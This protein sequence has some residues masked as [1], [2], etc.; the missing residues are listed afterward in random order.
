M[1]LIYPPAFY[2][3]Y[4][5]DSIH[6]IDINKWLIIN[7]FTPSYVIVNSILKNVITSCKGI[8]LC[9]IVKRY[10]HVVQPNELIK[11]VKNLINIGIIYTSLEDINFRKGPPDPYIT[12]TYFHITYRC[13]YRCLYCYAPPL[14]THHETEAEYWIEAA[15]NIISYN[16]SR[17][18]NIKPLIVISGGEPFIRSDIFHIISELLNIGC[19]VG[20][21]TNA[22]LIDYDKADMLKK[23]IKSNKN[24][25]LLPLCVS[26]D[27]YIQKINDQQRILPGG[28]AYS[29][30]MRGIKILK[31]K[32]IPFYTESTLT[33]L[34]SKTAIG[35]LKYFFSIST[36]P[37][38]HTFSLFT[39]TGKGA[40]H[41][42]LDLLQNE[43]KLFRI[44][45]EIK[46]LYNVLVKRKTKNIKRGI[47]LR[48]NI[49]RTLIIEP[50]RFK[51]V[52]INS[53]PAATRTLSLDPHLNVFPCHM[54]MIKELYGGTFF[55]DRIYDI[56]ESK[57]FR[58]I[59]NIVV[60]DNIY[61]RYCSIKYWCGGRCKAYTYFHYNNDI[62]A[63]YNKRRPFCSHIRRTVFKWFKS[64]ALNISREEYN[65]GIKYEGKCKA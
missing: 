15:K 61:C 63:L 56:I 45:D 5:K 46:K 18:V 17:G 20:I 30:T 14:I 16:E 59:R 64:K 65:K 38:Y 3:E 2:K 49:L 10:N 41:R 47:G 27:S 12:F 6:K 34:S 35:T 42:Y 36:S 31:S 54:F 11:I 40:Y 23:L 33:T 37:P 57:S 44:L 13:N 32:D 4:L 29:A 26:I 39:P 55:K 58:T 62:Q 52:I 7:P 9:E 51:G 60:D 1:Q 24:G 19:N 25:K 50:M 21:I 48:E 22:S 43:D 8:D 28:S 53:C